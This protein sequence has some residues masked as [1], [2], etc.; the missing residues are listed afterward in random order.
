VRGRRACCREMVGDH[1]RIRAHLKFVLPIAPPPNSTLNLRLRPHTTLHR[2]RH[3]T[4]FLF[5]ETLDSLRTQIPR[6]LFIGLCLEVGTHLRVGGV[7]SVVSQSSRSWRSPPL[8]SHATGTTTEGGSVAGPSYS[9]TT[10]SVQPLS[11]MHTCASSSPISSS[12]PTVLP[13]LLSHYSISL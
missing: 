11:R 6:R 8:N 12:Y 9:S 7:H 5:P 4:P 1:L 13:L 2:G 10:R 3:K